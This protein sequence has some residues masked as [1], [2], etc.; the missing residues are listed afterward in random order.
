MVPPVPTRKLGSQGLHA[1][2]QGLGCMGM[3][4]FYTD[5]RDHKGDEDSIATIH[6]AIE[7]GVTFLDTSDVYGPYTN[8]ELVGKD[9]TADMCRMRN[10]QSGQL[11]L[12]LLG[13]RQSAL[14]ANTAAAHLIWSLSM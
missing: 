9:A 10:K 11:L 1:S 2:I 6:R 12:V 3:S 7:L 13:S 4:G 14:L 8:E 5:K